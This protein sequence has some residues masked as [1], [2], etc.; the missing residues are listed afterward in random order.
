MSDST[1]ALLK[2]AQAG[3]LAAVMNALKDGAD[4]NAGDGS[5]RTALMWASMNHSIPVAEALLHAGANVNLQTSDGETALITASYGRGDAIGL[6]LAAGA[7]PT[8][9]DRK[10]KTALMWLVD[11]Q[12]H[13][14]LDARL[15]V[16][17]SDC[18]PHRWRR[19]G[20]RC[21]RYGPDGALWAVSGFRGDTVRSDE[22]QALLQNGADVHVT[23]HFGETPMFGLLRS[24]DPDAETLGVEL[25]KI[26][27]D[28]GADPN[29]RNNA[30]KT[31][32]G[33]ALAIP[34]WIEKLKGLG[35][36]E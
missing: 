26:L 5:G 33:V 30:G 32:L 29:A 34:S 24:I 1:E 14:E 12:L 2:A 27:L 13:S 16:T 17:A 18:A 20:K 31:P 8:I 28:A 25:V 9:A 3:D 36:T 21:R 7:D 10:N 15:D 6:L 23:D 4:V 19:A 35:F 22:L 11:P